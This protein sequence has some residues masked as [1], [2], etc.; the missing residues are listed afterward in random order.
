MTRKI[1]SDNQLM[2]KANIAHH[3]D[4]LVAASFVIF[5]VSPNEIGVGKIIIVEKN[6]DL[7]ASC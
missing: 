4:M 6:S 5:E 7:A 2:S 1:A 3:R